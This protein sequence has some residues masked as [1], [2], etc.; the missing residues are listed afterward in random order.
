MPTVPSRTASG[1][2]AEMPGRRLREP[3]G[4]GNRQPHG[5]EELPRRVGER[6]APRHHQPQPAADARPDLAEHERVR[7][8]PLQRGPERRLLP[9]QPRAR[10]RRPDAHGPVKQRLADRRGVGHGVEHRVVELLEHARDAGHDRR[11]RADQV[12]GHGLQR[13]GERHFAAE[14]QKHVQGQ[15]LE[16]VAERQERQRLVVAAD[17]HDGVHRHQVRQDVAVRQHHALGMARRPG[18]VDDRGD[19]ACVNPLRLLLV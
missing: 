18:R 19:V 2:L 15:P 7:Q 4:L 11:A 13:F 5:E 16:H 9:R 12:P 1:G 17:L 8:G 14:Q 3:V 10:M 6:R